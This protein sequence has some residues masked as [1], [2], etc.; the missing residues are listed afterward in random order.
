[1]AISSASI[2][3]EWKGRRNYSIVFKIF[4]PSSGCFFLNLRSL[5]LNARQLFQQDSWVQLLKFWPFWNNEELR[6]RFCLAGKK[7]NVF[8]LFREKS[9]GRAQHKAGVQHQFLR[10]ASPDKE[11]W[12]CQLWHLP[13]QRGSHPGEGIFLFQSVSFPIPIPI[14]RVAYPDP[15]Y[16]FNMDPDPA[17]CQSDVSSIRIWDVYTGS[18]IGFF[19][20]RIQGQK[21]PRSGSAFKNLSIFYPKNCF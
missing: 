20:S 11:A 8:L 4:G 19:P 17:P 21:D 18:R 1:M 12:L 10:G 7:L 16:H 2:S 3:W 14:W 9:A 5:V 13:A 15:T 6:N